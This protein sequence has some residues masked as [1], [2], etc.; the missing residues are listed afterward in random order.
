MK[1]SEENDLAGPDGVSRTN[2]PRA[3]AKSSLLIIAVFVGVL[4]LIAV[5]FWARR[6]EKPV[7]NNPDAVSRLEPGRAQATSA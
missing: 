1:R 3:G 5:Y 2:S 6:A 4:L 7:Q